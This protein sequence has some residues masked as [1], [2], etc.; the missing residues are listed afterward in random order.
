MQVYSVDLYILPVLMI[1]L[2][3]LNRPSHTSYFAHG[4]IEVV[5]LLP[6]AIPCRILAL[7][8]NLSTYMA[9]NL[10]EERDAIVSVTLIS[11]S[12]CQLLTTDH[13]ALTAQRAR[14][15]P[16]LVRRELPQF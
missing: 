4:T 5:L 13:T 7:Q 9:R 11:F 1:Y 2:A 10:K 6:L 15:L 3:V 8:Y 16:A 14:A 12:I